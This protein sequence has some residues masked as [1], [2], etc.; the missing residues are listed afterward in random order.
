MTSQMCRKPGAPLPA[1]GANVRASLITVHGAD[2]TLD[3]TYCVGSV[4]RL[5]GSD[6][7]SGLH[8]TFPQCL[9]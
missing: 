4:C 5:L 1:A 2:L 9:P 3:Y 7:S 8:N 6:T